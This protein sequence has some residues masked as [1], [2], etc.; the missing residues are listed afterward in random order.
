VDAW[1]SSRIGWDPESYESV[2]KWDGIRC[3]QIHD[4]VQSIILEDQHINWLPELPSELGL[5]TGLKEIKMRGNFIGG[6]IPFEVSSLPSLE[7]IDLS[8]NPLQGS[9]P[10]FFSSLLREISLPNCQLDGTIHFL[11][12]DSMQGLKYL[13]I[14]GNKITGTLPSSFGEMIAMEYLDL[15]GNSLQGSLPLE[16][17]E[18]QLLQMMFLNDNQFI[19]KFPSSLVG[20]NNLQQLFLYGNSFS[21]TIPAALGDLPNLTNLFIDGNKFTGTI[22]REVCERNFNENWFMGHES[23]IGRDGCTSVACPTNTEAFHQGV[24]PCSEC[25][26]SFMNPYLGSNEC[27][28]LNPKQILK[29]A[30]ITMN[31]EKWENA[32]T[33]QLADHAGW[34]SNIDECDLDGVECNDNRHIVSINLSNK[35]LSGNIPQELAFLQFVRFLD[36]SDNN[37]TGYLPSDF[38]WQPLEEL[39]VSGNKISGFI[40]PMLCEK[41]D[42]NGNGQGGHF[43]CD[44][45][46]CP[47]GTFNPDGTASKSPCMTCF[48]EDQASFLG[49]KSCINKAVGVQTLKTNSSSNTNMLAIFVAIPIIIGIVGLTFIGFRRYKKMQDQKKSEYYSSNG[50][51]T[52]SILASYLEKQQASS[53][54]IF[55]DNSRATKKLVNGHSLTFDV[56]NE[57]QS[58]GQ[59][60]LDVPRGTYT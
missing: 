19:G 16:I 26:D 32:K 10:R 7:V 20:A 30:Y 53:K 36:L 57:I 29:Q 14:S 27:I 37:L 44:N 1:T 13:D 8:N 58:D 38:R 9:L 39:N 15:S 49:Q 11:F 48:D 28:S 43:S 17:K 45:I 60:W 4:Q 56:Q 40:P 35:N 25:K 33:W 21:G 55:N 2:C 50:V 42:L 59:A 24:Y 54:S 5:L 46:A 52:K 22:P 47:S 18:L 41:S 23:G 6:N 31:G 51:V 12:G 3:D 34:G